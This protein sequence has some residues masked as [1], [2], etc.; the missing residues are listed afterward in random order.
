MTLKNSQPTSLSLIIEG[1]KGF[2][3]EDEG[4]KYFFKEA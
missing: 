2:E 3:A 4:G 1:I